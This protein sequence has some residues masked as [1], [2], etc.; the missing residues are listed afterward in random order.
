M[1]IIMAEKESAAKAIAEGIGL[2]NEERTKE[3][4]IKGI[5]D[6]EDVIIVHSQGHCVELLEPSDI[7]EKY[8]KW[9][10]ENL[11]IP[12]NDNLLKVKEGKENRVKAITGYLKQAT[13]IINAGD[14]GR[15]GELIQRWI[16]K[17]AGIEKAQ[18]LRLWTSSMTKEAVQKAYIEVCM[19]RINP[20]QKKEEAL[21]HLYDAGRARAVLDKYMGYNYSR[22]ISLTKTDGVTVNY[23][24]CKS[25]LTHAIIERDLEIENFKKRP[26]S[27]VSV[28][29]QNGSD[30]LKAV[31]IDEDGKRKE[32]ADS[33]EAKETAQGLKGKA[34]I[35]SIRKEMNTKYPP[36]PYDIL[37]L[38]KEMSKKYDYDA[39]F[40]LSI[41]QS[42][43]D[44]HKILSYPR[45][46]SRYLT[47]DLKNELPGTLESL[48]F[49]KFTEAA[50]VA[51][52]GSIHSRYFND[53]KVVDHHGLIPV[54]NERIRQE[55][56]K[57]NEAEK[58]VYDAVILNFLSLFM[59]PMQ[60][61]NIQVILSAGGEKL[62]FTAKHTLQQGFSIIAGET[63]NGED[64]AVEISTADLKEGDLF[65]INKAECVD[66]E[67]KPKKHFTTASLL[68]F[69]KVHNIGTGAT[70]DG[71]IKE[72]TERKGRNAESAVMR[73][74]KYFLSTDFGRSMDR[75]I[76]DK[77]KSIDFLSDVDTKLAAIEQGELT[78]SKFY[79]S[80]EEEFQKDYREMTE[81]REVLMAQKKPERKAF[82]ICPRCGKPVFENSK[83]YS[84]SGYKDG[85]PFVIWKVMA[86]KKLPVSAVRKLLEGKETKVI[87][88]F[89]SKT[90]KKFDAALKLN[91]DE[92][93]VEFVFK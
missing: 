73:D 16:L 62:K 65:D 88:G 37:T 67:T 75:L 74:G 29:L 48:N 18:I 38:Q 2:I 25:P 77:L 50:A 54:G 61:E 3:G 69:M 49:G 30:N 89:R 71:I 57:L 14:S 80:M 58:N 33:K 36:K 32:Y 68:D 83:A 66:T 92:S 59:P 5:E 70:R 72:L 35:I 23:G 10:I 24:R 11:P 90:G 17:Y 82:G 79:K 40:T 8:E 63:E 42:L 31:V 41:C 87:T 6:R 91:E 7:D 21:N 1:I 43:Y 55:Y 46:D 60:Y 9:R 53:K 4:F 84:C 76:P 93:G 28:A 15:E 81:N 22:L 78:Y 19:N 39:D 45:T 64:D 52:E 56:E 34:E 86:G 51:K 44:A 13:V 26:Y 47:E 85:C 20:D 27:F 12:F